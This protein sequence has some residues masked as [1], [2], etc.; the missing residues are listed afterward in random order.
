MRLS[1]LEYEILNFFINKEVREIS[2]KALRNEMVFNKKNRLID[3]LEALKRLCRKKVLYQFGDT[4]NIKDM[5]KFIQAVSRLQRSHTAELLHTFV[6]YSKDDIINNNTAIINLDNAISL[7]LHKTASSY[8]VLLSKQ[9]SK[10]KAICELRARGY[11]DIIS[12]KT[13]KFNYNRLR[14]GLIIILLGKLLDTKLP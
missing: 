9:S 1:E 14:R 5:S 4:V 6:V 11:I 8:I 12:Y 10:R 13:Y 3:F 7:T 2:F